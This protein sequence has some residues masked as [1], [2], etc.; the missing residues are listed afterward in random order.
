MSEQTEE[1]VAFRKVKRGN[2]ATARP[3][4]GDEP[5]PGPGATEDVNE[6][7]ILIGPLPE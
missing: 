1:V 5:A 6:G 2:R 3:R 7:V 4:G